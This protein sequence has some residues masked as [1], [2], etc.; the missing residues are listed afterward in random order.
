[1]TETQKKMMRVLC[2]VTAPAILLG[3]LLAGYTRLPLLVSVFPMFVG[4]VV[5]AVAFWKNSYVDGFD[6]RLNP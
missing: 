5:A 1:M 4:W 3:A 6:R 2:L